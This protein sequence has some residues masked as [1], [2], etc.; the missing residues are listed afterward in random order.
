MKKALLLTLGLLMCLTLA[1]CKKE[2]PPVTGGWSEVED[3]TVTDELRE[4]FDKAVEGLT[5]VN[6]E[7][8][9]LLRT[10][11]VAGMNYEFLVTA[12][13]VSP[14]AKPEEK[15]MV[16]YRDLEGKATV[17]SISDAK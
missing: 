17:S 5:G 14:D 11:L 2:E 13:V 8:V 1:G 9:K 4:I 12:T 6:Y 16:I 10:Q 7:P 15:I 3:G